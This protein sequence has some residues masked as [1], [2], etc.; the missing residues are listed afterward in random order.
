MTRLSLVFLWGI[1]GCLYPFLQSADQAAR[2][3]QTQ[4]SLAEAAGATPRTKYAGDQSCLLCHKDQALSYLHT[5]HHLTSQSPGKDS[6]L[7]SFEEGANVLKIADPAP[8]IGDPGLSYRMENYGGSYSVTAVSGFEGQWKRRSEQIAIVIGSGMR[9]Q[10]YLYW[11]GDQLFELPVSYWPD[12]RQWINSPGFRNGP[13]N[14]DRVVSQRC[15]EC[16]ATYIRALSPDPAT[17]RYDKASLVTGISCE[18]CHGPGADHVAMH[19]ASPSVAT[20]PIGIPSPRTRAGRAARSLKSLPSRARTSSSR[21]GPDRT[22]KSRS[23]PLRSM[24][25]MA[26]RTIGRSGTGCLRT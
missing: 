7:G 10:S 1:L 13:P 18:T 24:D 3:A 11:R 12:G 23:G 6:I 14:F 9:G 16:H 22:R 17:N 15:V 21:P 4:N 2:G 19:R 20:K 26:G 25:V 5:A 8:V